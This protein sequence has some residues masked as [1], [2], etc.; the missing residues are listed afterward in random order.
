MSMWDMLTYM[1]VSKTN[2]K[3]E[4]MNREQREYRENQ[5]SQ[6]I[7]SY[8]RALF[9]NLYKNDND[10]SKVD[11]SKIPQI[12]EYINNLFNNRKF[13]AYKP[14]Y[15]FG[16]FIFL[17]I[18]VFLKYYLDSQCIDIIEILKKQNKNKD[19]YE[20][21]K[22]LYNLF[23]LDSKPIMDYNLDIVSSF[24]KILISKFD[25]LE[26]PELTQ[27][28]GNYFI[29]TKIFYAN[30]TIYEGRLKN[31]FPD[32][33]GKMKYNNGDIYEGEFKEGVREGFGKYYYNNGIYYEGYWRNGKENGKG[34][35]KFLDGCIYNGDFV[36][37]EMRGYAIVDCPN[38]KY[39]GEFKNN[40]KNGKGKLILNDE[41]LE[42]YFKDNNFI[43]EEKEIK[44][45]K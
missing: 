13:N 41:I 5:L 28:D 8:I 37:G 16:M 38:Y 9:Q 18:L 21:L 2:E 25:K 35:I 23:D 34:K 10:I 33:K 12:K 36:N 39:E 43:G 20:T 45:S 14:K 15:D 7:N 30:G 29:D 1:E 40:M 22:I 19:P 26:I 31:G 4:R 24:N 32:G 6:K 44:F 11:I 42:G 27:L 17:I 3:L